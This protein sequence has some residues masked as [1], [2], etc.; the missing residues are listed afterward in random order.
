MRIQSRYNVYKQ[1][2]SDIL[3]AN[4]DN[5]VTAN[6]LIFLQKSTAN[7]KDYADLITDIIN[8]PD[9]TKDNTG[10]NKTDKKTL[11]RNITWRYLDTIFFNEKEMQKIISVEDVF[12]QLKQNKINMNVLFQ[13]WKSDE[14]REFE[15]DIDFGE[16]KSY[17]TEQ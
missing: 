7:S 13:D 12:K 5:L 10:I 17:L 8:I 11:I 4:P 16:I 2:I 3:S 9:K 6:A 15:P 1:N 14:I